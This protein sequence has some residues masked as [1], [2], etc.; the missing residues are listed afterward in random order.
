MGLCAN[1]NGR[2]VSVADPVSVQAIWG[3][4]MWTW[5]DVEIGMRAW[6]NVSGRIFASDEMSAEFPR[7]TALSFN[8]LITFHTE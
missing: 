5:W 1:G 8:G 3:G 2:D 7:G 4:G 6:Q